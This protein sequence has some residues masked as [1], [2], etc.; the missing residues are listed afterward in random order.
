METNNDKSKKTM[1]AYRLDN[2]ILEYLE[3]IHKRS[4]LTITYMLET[5]AFEKA[6]KIEQYLN[7]QEK[8]KAKENEKYSDKY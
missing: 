8:E 6:Q 2:D 1:R 5:G 4:G 7:I 3:K